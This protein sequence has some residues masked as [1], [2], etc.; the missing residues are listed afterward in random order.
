MNCT[1]TPG[2]GPLGDAL[3]ITAPEQRVTTQTWDQRRRLV[4]LRNGASETTQYTHDG[5]GQIRA[6][7]PPSSADRD[8]HRIA[9]FLRRSDQP[10]D[11]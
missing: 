8:R 10:T 4:A 9:D 6:I 1:L 3:T 5:L 11:V 7:T 2:S